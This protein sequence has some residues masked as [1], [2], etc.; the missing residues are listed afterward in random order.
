MRNAFGFT[1]NQFL[2]FGGY[3]DAAPLIRDERRSHRIH[4]ARSVGNENEAVGCAV[5]RT[6]PIPH[7]RPASP[8]RDANIRGTNVLLSSLLAFWCIRSLRL[9]SS[10]PAAQP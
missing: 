6:A 7:A 8:A 3:P 10:S 5:A 9:H 1:L 2:F 4:V